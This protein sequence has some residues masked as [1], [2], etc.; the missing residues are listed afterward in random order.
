MLS[1]QKTLFLDVMFIS[2]SSRILS[3]WCDICSVCFLLYFVENV[4]IFAMIYTF[5]HHPSNNAREWSAARCG[6]CYT[7]LRKCCVDV[8]KMLLLKSNAVLILCIFCA[9]LYGNFCL[10]FYR[11]FLKLND[12]PLSRR[13]LLLAV[14]GDSLSSKGML[15]R[16]CGN[17]VRMLW[18]FCADHNGDFCDHST[19]FS[20]QH[21]L[22]PLFNPSMDSAMESCG[23]ML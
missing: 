15:W 12:R 7:G 11:Y 22:T 21:P 19:V 2:S 13:L 23:D 14:A 18:L 8:V 6:G 5:V 10:H 4:D 17:A 16:C 20:T 9:K 1:L 3:D